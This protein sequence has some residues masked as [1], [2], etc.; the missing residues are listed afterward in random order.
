MAEQVVL[1]VEK[2]TVTGKAVRNLRR[3]GTLPANLTGRKQEAEAIQ[4]NAHEF[5][6]L[7]KAH[8]RTTIIKL[9]IAP[10]SQTQNAVIGRVSRDPIS[11]AIEHIDFRHVIMTEVMRARVPLHVVGESPAV[12]AREGILLHLI[13]D[14]EVEALPANLPESI[15]VDVSSLDAV[16]AAIH[17]KDLPLPEKVKAI[18]DGEEP[19]IK[20]TQTR[21]AIEEEAAAAATEEEGEAAPE[22]ESAPSEAEE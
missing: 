8:G 12:K 13:N 16:D 11:G 21:A 4:V 17:V 3:A 6:K 1:Q 2:R 20:V 19:V 14:L 5:E 10:S 7:L 15:E 22:A 18:T 9:A